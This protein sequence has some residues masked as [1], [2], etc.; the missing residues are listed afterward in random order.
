LSQDR[1]YERDPVFQNRWGIS[2]LAKRLAFSSTALFHGVSEL[3][4]G[5]LKYNLATLVICDCNN[6]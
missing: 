5:R 3:I 4:I 2:L 1:N 6:R